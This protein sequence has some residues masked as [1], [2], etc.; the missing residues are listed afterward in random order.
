MTMPVSMPD[1]PVPNDSSS[2]LYDTDADRAR[3]MVDID[4]GPKT[5]L[6]EKLAD[7]KSPGTRG[8]ETGLAA[9]VIRRHVRRGS[10]EY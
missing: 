10:Q 4:F 6:D 5:L 9:E 1:P 2:D 7:E 3:H 8:D